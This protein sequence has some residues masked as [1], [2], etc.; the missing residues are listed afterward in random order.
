MPST[1]AAVVVA[2]GA[3]S[4]AEQAGILPG[5]RVVAV[6]GEAIADAAGLRARLADVRDED[7]LSIALE[8]AGEVRELEL[9]AAARALERHPGCDVVYAQMR[10]AGH[11]LRT[12]VTSPAPTSPAT[13]LPY[14]LFV[15]GHGAGSVDGAAD[16]DRPIAALSAACARAGHVFV[17]FDRSGV[18]D[19]EGPHPAEL[20]FADELDQV[21]RAWTFASGLPNV[22]PGRGIL[23]AHSLGTLPAVELAGRASTRPAGLSIYGGGLKLWTEYSDDNCRRQWT[24]AGVSLVEQDRALRVLARFHAL[25]LVQRRPLSEVLARMPEIQEEPELFAVES[26]RVLRGRP[27]HYW[28]DVYDAPV[29][30]QLQRAGLPTLAAWGEMDW[31][32]SRTDHELIAACVAEAHP[33]L[34]SF[35]A[36]AGA[37]HNFTVRGSQAEAFRARDA[38]RLSDV[39]VATFLSWAASVSGA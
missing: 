21:A 24:L 31:M 13:K 39:W 4:P 25:L 16:P 18:G 22:A 15:P 32:S 17:R 27:D 37:D 11:R 23:L 34:G 29:A 35:R 33:G 26:E 28:Q 20:G 8:R 6:D 1:G 3:N 5:D 19:S 38:G 12:I 10:C 14:V 30:E 7:R 36:I 9:V 2:L